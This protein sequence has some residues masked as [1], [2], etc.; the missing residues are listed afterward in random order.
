MG[1]GRIAAKSILKKGWLSQDLTLCSSVSN[2]IF[3]T[4]SSQ[5]YPPFLL[6]RVQRIPL[7]EPDGKAH[8]EGAASAK[9]RRRVS[10][11]GH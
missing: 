8:H 2:H 4:S 3:S 6:R 9:P 11:Y 10:V 7:G 1:A 5:A